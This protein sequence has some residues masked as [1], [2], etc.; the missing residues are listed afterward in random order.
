MEIFVVGAGVQSD[1]ALPFV[2]IWYL[3]ANVP[4]WATD[5]MFLIFP[6]K[7]TLVF[8][9]GE[10]LLMDTVAVRSG[11]GMVN[12]LSEQLLVSFSSSIANEG[13]SAHSLTM[14]VPPTAVQLEEVTPTESPW[15]RKDRVG[16]PTSTLL[17]SLP[18]I[19]TV[20]WFENVCEEIPVVPLFNIV[21]LKL[22]ALPGASVP[23]VEGPEEIFRSG[24]LTVQATAGIE[25]ADP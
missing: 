6:L 24:L 10:A 23:E 8:V 12:D 1:H 20:N 5:P 19:K 7:V 11:R 14:C 21:P 22:T 13:W 17:L 9:C 15:F 2:L 3:F 4:I 25:L 18:P 16:A